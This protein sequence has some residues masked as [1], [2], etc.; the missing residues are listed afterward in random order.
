M[1]VTMCHLYLHFLI[2]QIKLKYYV[3]T[4]KIM[5]CF[6]NQH[7]TYIYAFNI[8]IKLTKRKSKDRDK[9][10]MLINHLVAV[11]S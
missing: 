1:L 5:C 11:L 10:T 6:F 2:V 7:I 8:S 3:N 9:T 4:P